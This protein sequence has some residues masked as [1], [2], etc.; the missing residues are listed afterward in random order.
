MLPGQS[1]LGSPVFEEH[2]GELMSLASEQFLL[3]NRMPLGG[4][5]SYQ[6]VGTV[7]RI[8]GRDWP[9]ATIVC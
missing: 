6:E 7:A 9:L 3:W 8:L 1:L 4:H 2:L 5:C